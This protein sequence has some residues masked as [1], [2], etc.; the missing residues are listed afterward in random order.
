MSTLVVLIDPK[1]QLTHEYYRG[2]VKLYRVLETDEYFVISA[3]NETWVCITSIFKSDETGF[4][5]YSIEL[6]GSYEGGAD[7]N[8]ALRRGDYIVVNDE[9]LIEGEVVIIS[10]ELTI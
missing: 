4:V 5:D 1:V 6:N 2:S 8:E 7:H 9:N 10:G 3:V